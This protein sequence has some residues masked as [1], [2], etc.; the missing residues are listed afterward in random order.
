M[1]QQLNLHGDCSPLA[2]TVLFDVKSDTG[3]LLILIYCRAYKGFAGRYFHNVFIQLISY[4][5]S[6]RIQYSWS[7]EDMLICR[8]F[9]SKAQKLSR[10]ADLKSHRVGQVVVR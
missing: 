8:T 4:V 1:A 6:I 7:S 5:S 10:N 2:C 9:L 3:R